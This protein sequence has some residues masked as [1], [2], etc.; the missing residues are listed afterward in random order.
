MC[1][2]Q[3]D[4]ADKDCFKI[5]ILQETLRTQNEH[6]GDSCAF[7]EV[8]HLFQ[9]VGCARNKLQFDTVPRK[10]KLFLLVQVHAWTEL[11]RLIFGTW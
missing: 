8:K 1:E 11:A 9:K 4:N 5:L 10:L 7:S 3:R 2:T 6:Q